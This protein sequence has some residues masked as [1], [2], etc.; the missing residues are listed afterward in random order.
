MEDLAVAAALLAIGWLAL[1]AST[2]AI[3]AGVG[4]CVA[5]TLAL[6][7]HAR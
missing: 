7:R 1:P 3:V 4:V 2:F 5:I 6:L